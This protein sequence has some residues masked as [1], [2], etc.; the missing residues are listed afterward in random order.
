MGLSFYDEKSLK[1]SIVESLHFAFKQLNTVTGDD[2]RIQEH[3]DA[4][5]HP[6]HQSDDIEMV[7]R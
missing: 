4:S 1:E 5:I 2:G 7:D 3:N 6:S